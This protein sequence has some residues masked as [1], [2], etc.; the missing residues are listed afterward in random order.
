MFKKF[1]LRVVYQLTRSLVD[2]HS[3]PLKSLTLLVI[4]MCHVKR[5]CVGALARG[6]F[7]WKPYES[8]YRRVREFLRYSVF[9]VEQVYGPISAGLLIKLAHLSP[10]NL[11][12]VIMDWTD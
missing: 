11:I 12:P 10:D 5:A 1:A 2:F 6:I 7:S 4:A 8:L 9:A 3:T